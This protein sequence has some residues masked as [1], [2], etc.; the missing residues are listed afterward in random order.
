MR[1]EPLHAHEQTQHVPLASVS[2]HMVRS[3]FETS[4]SLSRFCPVIRT[5]TTFSVEQTIMSSVVPS[6]GS[7]TTSCVAQVVTPIP[8][9]GF[10]TSR[11]KTLYSWNMGS[12]LRQFGSAAVQV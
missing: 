6:T 10:P 11:T 7:V 1:P 12:V 5:F 9:L 2:R 8:V 4:S 3:C